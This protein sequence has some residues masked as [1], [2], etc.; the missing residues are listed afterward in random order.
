MP[1]L[2]SKKL[3]DIINRDV[4]KDYLNFG[5]FAPNEAQKDIAYDS[6]AI[7]KLLCA[8]VIEIQEMNQKIDTLNNNLNPLKDKNNNAKKKMPLEQRVDNLEKMVKNIVKD[9]WTNICADKSPTETEDNLPTEIINK[10]PVLKRQNCPR[11]YHSKL[12]CQSYD[13]GTCRGICYPTYPQQYD[14]CVFE[15]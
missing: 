14:P 4:T 1:T 8:L 12:G 9:I 15:E 3:R 2:D 6:A 10:K 11:G 7:K 13:K 5:A